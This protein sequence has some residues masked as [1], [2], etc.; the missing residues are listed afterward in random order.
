MMMP[1]LIDKYDV[2][3]G[4]NHIPN[5]K[6]L[7]QSL[8][9]D[10]DGNYFYFYAKFQKSSS[11]YLKFITKRSSGL[12]TLG[13]KLLQE[14]TESFTYFILGAQARSCWPI[15]G[16][17]AK[18]LPTQDVFCKIVEVTRDETTTREKL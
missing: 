15:V 5:T 6:T 1:N 17:G 9:K 2:S 14:S 16:Q 3:V 10:G 18:S 13:T 12:A 7:V 4:C 11:D 8:T